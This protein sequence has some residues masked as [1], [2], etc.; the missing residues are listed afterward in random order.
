MRNKMPT[1]A[2]GSACVCSVIKM[3]SLSAYVYSTMLLCYCRLHSLLCYCRLHSLDGLDLSWDNS[4]DVVSPSDFTLLCKE[5]NE[6]FQSESESTNQQRLL[7][8]VTLAAD[9]NTIDL[10]Y[11]PD[12]L[13][14]SVFYGKPTGEFGLA[15]LGSRPEN[16]QPSL[17]QTQ[18]RLATLASEV[19][20]LF[21]IKASD[22]S[23][24]LTDFANPT[25]WIPVIMGWL[26]LDC[27]WLNR[28]ESRSILPFLLCCHCCDF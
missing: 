18:L 24:R 17:T 27:H 25:C 21:S 26:I 12:Q 19:S 28:N 3:E 23:G 1:L 10:S 14:R 7:L 22:T 4:D 2:L 6:A 20:Y 11:E 15:W 8:T 13:S 9:K 5:I 16:P